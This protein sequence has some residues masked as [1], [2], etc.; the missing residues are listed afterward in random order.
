MGGLEGHGAGDNGIMGVE[1]G[2]LSNSNNDEVVQC[3]KHKQYNVY[4]LCVKTSP[5]LLTLRKD[6][7]QN[8]L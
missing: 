1:T 5:K 7:G 6:L 4:V 3:N 8:L 2:A